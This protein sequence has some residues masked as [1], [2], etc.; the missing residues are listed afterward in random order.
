MEVGA[1]TFLSPA[2]G[3]V[4]LGIVVPIAALLL[5]DRRVAR[6]RALLRLASPGREGWRTIVA[7]LAAVPLLLGVAASQPAVRTQHGTRLRTDAQALFVLDVSRSM[8]ASAEPHRR[9]RLARAREAAL[10]LHSE[11]T[12]VPSGVGTL[13]D[14]V[15]PDLF[16]TGDAAAFASTVQHIGIEQPPPQS[17]AVNATTLAPLADV[18]TEGYYAPAARRRLLVVLT[19]G[20]S[21]AFSAAEVAR[22]LRSGPGVS[23]VLVR[24]WAEGERVFGLSGQPESYLPDPQSGPTLAGLAAATGG[25]VFAERDLGAAAAFARSALGTGPT[26]ARG[27]EVRT[28]PLAPYVAAA[29]FVPLLFVLRRRNV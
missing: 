5:A 4:A 8:L 2:G 3:L 15:L 25:R 16:P 7:A 26:T 28:T 27:R 20:E 12:E 24:V 22:A 14:R 21:Q 29:A 9:T 19:D 18:A 11:L 23:L 10:R 1:L 17:I 13:T 6:A